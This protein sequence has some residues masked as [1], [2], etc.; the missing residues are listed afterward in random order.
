MVTKPA[1]NFMPPYLLFLNEEE[2]EIHVHQPADAATYTKT[3]LVL[4]DT[5]KDCT[6]S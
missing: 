4:R 3:L 2:D 5:S 6:K 1:E